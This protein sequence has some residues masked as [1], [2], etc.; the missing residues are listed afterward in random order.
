MHLLCPQIIS[1]T[2]V[3]LSELVVLLPTLPKVVDSANSINNMLKRT[4]EI[5][6]DEQDSIEPSSLTGYIELKD[7]YFRYPSRPEVQVLSNVNLH[8]KAGQTVALVGESG[9]GKSSII[10]LVERFYDV[11]GGQVFI[12]NVDIKQLNLNWLRQRIGLV[13]QEPTLFNLSIRENILY[14]REGASETEMVEAAKSANAHTFI[15]GLPQGYGTLVGDRGTQLS[16]GQKQRVAI[17]RAIL[18]NPSI[19]LLDEAT[20]ALD[21]ESEKVVQEALDRLLA[22]GSKTTLVVAHRLSTIQDAD[23]IVVLS[24]GK[25]KEQGSHSTL[26]RKG[27]LYARLLATH[28]NQN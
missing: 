12:D 26:L 24:K 25:I 27:G 14:G 8:I 11:T 23:V 22:S 5:D 17:A 1:N 15:S 18:K 13:Q 2:S 10:S 6:P 7:V 4:T 3:N 16:G 28:K 21:T 9:S 20:S 19:L